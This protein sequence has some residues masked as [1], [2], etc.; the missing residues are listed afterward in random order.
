MTRTIG[1]TEWTLGIGI[2]QTNMA[3]NLRL[4]TYNL[5]GF[6]MGLGFLSDLCNRN[7]IVAIQEHWLPKHKLHQLYTVNSNFCGYGISSMDDTNEHNI[8]RGRP[9]GGVG[10]LWRKELSNSIKILQS[11]VTGRCTAIAVDIGEGRRIV[12][13]NVYFP[14]YENTPVYF[15]ELGHCVGF[16]E[17]VLVNNYPDVVILGDFNFVC[18]QASAGFKYTNAVF[19][20]YGIT[21][22]DNLLTA[23]LPGYSY[24]HATLGHQSLVDHYFMTASL[25]Q[26][27]NTVTVVEHA[28]NLSDH[29]PVECELRLHVMYGLS[30]NRQVKNK[31]VVTR[32]DKTNLCDYYTA[33]DS[34]L[35]KIA[36][37][38]DCFDCFN[39]TNDA[40]MDLL[41]HQQC[42]DK[43]YD[44]IVNAVTNAA[45]QTVVTVPC[46]A[47][48]VF[49]NS[50]LDRL[51][52]DSIT[53]HNIW[54]N[55]GR[56]GSGIIH[57]IKCSCKLKYKQAIKEAYLKFEYANSDE[58]SM[59]FNNKRLPEFWKCWNRK[60]NKN[61]TKEVSING[62]CDNADVA[63]SFANFFSDVYYD[64]SSNLEAVNEYS[65]E[66]NCAQ[67]IHGL[68]TEQCLAM[69]TI[70]LIDK[71]VHKLKLGKACGPD[72]I[73]AEH[74]KNAHPSLMMHLKLLFYLIVRHSYVPDGFGKGY[75]IPLV[76]DK[77]GNL[78]DT[79]NYRAIT[80]GPVIAKAFESVVCDI[81]EDQLK[82]DDLQFGFKSG[83][84]CTDA[85]FLCRTTIDHFTER[86]SNVYA[87]ALD[88]S[89]AFD[90]VNHYKLFVSL[91]KAGIPICFVQL[92]MNWYSKLYV[93][94]KW[95]GS[96]SYWFSVGSGVR[97]GSV[98]SPALFTVFV[99]VF[100]VCIR[101]ADL[102]C[103]IN[104]TIVSCVL[105]ADDIILLS[106]S[107]SVLQRML[108]IVSQTAESLLLQFN[109]KKSTCIAFGPKIPK[110][111]PKLML[112]ND[113]VE[114]SSSINYLGVQ[115][116]SGVH[117]KTDIG[118]VKR[119]FYTACNCIISNCY[120]V[121]EVVQLHLQESYCLPL[122]T[123]AAPAL[124][125]TD[126]QLRELNVCWNSVYR[127]LFKFNRWESVKC[128]INGL[129]RLDLLHIHA[130]HKIKYCCRLNKCA[131][132]TMFRVFQ[133]FKLSNEYLRLLARYSC[134]PKDNLFNIGRNVTDHFMLLAML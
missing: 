66:L 105:Y 37:P 122:L 81:C 100:I 91:I 89:K 11:D 110:K 50:E 64:S 48:K 40:C 133:C 35:R 84:G 121:S 70:E 5:H 15:N 26:M 34:E 24:M 56:P 114:W 14:C 86:G 76:K 52:Q 112:G 30:G 46:S 131:N 109:A 87:A 44:D 63:N 123:Y 127:K 104:R 38:V 43:Y 73:S 51:K 23:D 29:L 39:C 78:N 13:I 62:S 94:V 88:V 101:S 99:N 57:K 27:V 113:T 79:N 124:R 53:W 36:V 6:N 42:I 82:T 20:E 128:F 119:K 95:N 69:F 9:F 107:A 93:A 77:S 31:L 116:M 33:T 68:K 17:S 49:W 1:Q 129:G 103:Y 19:Q 126:Q 21:N 67:S 61:V 41:T 74:L 18:T 132:T 3:H 65:E 83:M 7:D 90:K 4:A 55:A 47:L 120:N 134:G 108:N 45:A 72:G 98:L 32:W 2:S 25:I 75:V 97:Q 115:L 92:L 58:L 22:C 28:A 111:L 85:I 8:L 16:I 96:L 118:V 60:F 10:F 71:C 12:I 125:L 102:G 117:I 54:K 130:L 80:L 59:H 106:A